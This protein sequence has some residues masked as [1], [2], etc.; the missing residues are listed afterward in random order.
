M[1]DPPVPDPA[2][3]CAVRSDIRTTAIVIAA[4]STAS[5]ASCGPISL[6]SSGSADEVSVARVTFRPCAAGLEELGVACGVTTGKRLDR[7]PGVMVAPGSGMSVVGGSVGGTEGGL[8]LCPTTA[9]RAASAGDS[10][11]A[12]TV[13]ARAIGLPILAVGLTLSLTISSNA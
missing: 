7:P 10:P 5:P 8:M 9:A 3:A 12:D 2:G 13:T 6:E 1:P 4:A 11:L